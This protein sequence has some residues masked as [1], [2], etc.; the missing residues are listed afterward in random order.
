[1]AAYASPRPMTPTRHGSRVRVPADTP[2]SRGA[3]PAYHHVRTTSGHTPTHRAQ[4]AASGPAQA[5]AAQA[6]RYTSAEYANLTTSTPGAHTSLRNGH[7]PTRRH[8][9]HTTRS[10]PSVAQHTTRCST[11]HHQ[12]QSQHTYGASSIRSQFMTAEPTRTPSVLWLL[13]NQHPRSQRVATHCRHPP[14]PRPSSVPLL[15]APSAWTT[16]EGVV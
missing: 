6:I 3:H 12:E 1:M 16:V 9:R 8:I 7:M 11:T 4:Y 13:T 15:S 10:P 14:S 5:V 2:E